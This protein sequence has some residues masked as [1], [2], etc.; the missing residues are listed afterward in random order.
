MVWFLS[1]NFYFVSC[2]SFVHFKSLIVQIVAHQLTQRRQKMAAALPCSRRPS[3]V[4]RSTLLLLLCVVTQMKMLIMIQSHSSLII[5]VMMWINYQLNSWS[6]KSVTDPPRSV[7]RYSRD[8][9]AP[10]EMHARTRLFGIRRRRRTDGVNMNGNAQ[11][12]VH[13]WARRLL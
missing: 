7:G 1:L 3:A 13:K 4:F 12:H 6:H 2:C 9:E 11:A 8:A 10:R 5:L